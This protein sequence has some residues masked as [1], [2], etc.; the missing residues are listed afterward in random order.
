MSA[1]DVFENEMLLLFFNNTDFAGVGDAA[2]LQNSAAAG[3]LYVGLHTGDPLDAGPQ[4]ASET[5]YTGYARVA[6]ARSAAGWT[7]AANVVSNAGVVTF[8]QCTGAPATL[9]HFSIGEAAIGGSARMYFSAALT[10]P[11]NVDNLITPK[12]A[13]GD[14][15]VTAS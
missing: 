12:F 3:N 9:T 8:P 5:A 4:T 14:L 10:A 6:V 1:S 7:V 13:I 2:G 11:I 15:T